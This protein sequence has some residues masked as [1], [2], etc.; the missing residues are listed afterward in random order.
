M[1]RETL[2]SQTRLCAACPKMCRHVCPT[3]LAWRSDSPTPHGRAL[4]VYQDLKGVRPLDDRSI[5]VLYQCLECSHCLTWCLPEVDVAAIVESTRTRLVSEGREPAGIRELSDKIRE[6]HNPFGEP[7][8]SRLDWKR[9]KTSDG[10]KIVYFAG[11]TSSY[12]EKEIAESTVSVLSKVLG[13]SVTVSPEEWCCGSPLFRTGQLGSALEQAHH[14]TELLNS[15]EGEMVVTSCPGCYRSL[16]QDYQK[17]GLVVD[18]PVVHLSKLLSDSVDRLPQAESSPVITYH[19]PCHLGR[20]AGLYDEPRSVL[21]HVSKGQLVEMERNK[22][23]AMCCGNGAGLRALFPEE[24]RVI[25]RAR[26][27]QAEAT[28]ATQIVTACPFCKNMLASQARSKGFVVDLSEF[29]MSSVKSSGTKA[30]TD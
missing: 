28:G 9:P 27:E 7:H 26:I 2:L 8:S 6:S 17:H 4:L 1:E 18:K 21:K 11:C 22:D 10:R 12:R 20:H 13:Y 29:V 23:N 30:K 25:G 5:E 15:L 16:T 3:F 14:N 19:D 24:S